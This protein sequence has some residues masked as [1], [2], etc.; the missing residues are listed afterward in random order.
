[1][2]VSLQQGRPARKDGVWLRQAGR[3]NVLFDREA[4]RVHLI[5]HTAVAIWELCDGDTRPEEMIDAICEITGMPAEVVTEDVERILSD[6]D[7][8]GLIEWRG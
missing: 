2:M 8:A 5:N 3:E 4:E 6:F 1:M 7:E